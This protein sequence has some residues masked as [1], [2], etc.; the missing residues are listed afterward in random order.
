MVFIISKKGKIL[1]FS[2][3]KFENFKSKTK[4]TSPTSFV[5]KKS[6]FKGCS[7]TG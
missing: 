3:L 5:K 2:V 7:L 4:K 1:I 6:N